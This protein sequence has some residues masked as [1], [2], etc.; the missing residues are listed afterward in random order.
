MSG[1]LLYCII[2]SYMLYFFT[3]VFGLSVGVAGVLLLIGRVF[4]AIGAPIMG[5]L[6][7]HT[8]S[9]YGKSRPWFLWGALPFAIFVWLLF[10]T[11]DIS[12][13]AKIIYAGVMYIL[14]DFSYTAMSTPITSVLPNLTT[15]T[16]DRVQANSIRLVFLTIIGQIW[17][18]FAGSNTT[19]ALIGW[20]VA[21]IGAG[22]ACTMFFAMVGDTVDFGE[23]KTGIRANG[24][25]TAIGAAFCIQMGSGLGSFIVSMLLNSVGFD[26]SHAV[27]SA[28][29]LTG[30]HLSFIWVP[31]IIYIISLILMVTYRK[32]ERHEPVVQK[33]LVEREVEAEEA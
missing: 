21:C 18:G 33:E 8:H 15:N 31:I 17:M 14:A 10:T 29:S 7:D 13:T 32:W 11:P 30:I 28:S 22:S 5:I 26:A 24:F 23:W 25:L 27:Q 12:N 4:D 2:S 6:V 3:N 20:C 1:N 19:S 9:K 16:D